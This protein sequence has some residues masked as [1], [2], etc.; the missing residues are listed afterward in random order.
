MHKETIKARLEAQYEAFVQMISTLNEQEYVQAPEGKWNAGMQ[1]EHLC[2]SVAPVNLA[3]SLPAFLIRLVFG[4]ANRPSRSYEALVEKY[5]LKLSAGGRA[6]AP[7]VPEESRF[8]ERDKWSIKLQKLIKKLS[9]RVEGFSEEQLDSLILPHP[10]LGKLTLREM[11]FFTIYH[12]QHH[13]KSVLG[14]IEK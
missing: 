9:T 6:S 7:F 13:Q 12:A 10:L 2:K 4:K 14:M 3:F 8:S 5:Q 11:L 1:L